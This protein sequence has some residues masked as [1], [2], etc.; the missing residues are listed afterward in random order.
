MDNYL[1]YGR[2]SCP[3]C[4]QATKLLDAHQLKYNFFDLEFDRDFLNEAKV[5][6]DHRTVPI[7]LKVNGKSGIVE[8]IGGCDDLKGK[9]NDQ[10]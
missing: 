6:Y 4:V 9:L 1:I 10:L 5:F 2:S 8:F 3:Y 7:V